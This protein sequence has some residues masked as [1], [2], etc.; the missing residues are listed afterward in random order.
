MVTTTPKEPTIEAP[1][2]SHYEPDMPMAFGSELRLNLKALGVDGSVPDFGE[3]LVRLSRDNEPYDF[4]FS[5]RG[6]LIVMAPSGTLSNRDETVIN[7]DLEMYNR[8][9]LSLDGR[10]IG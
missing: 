6:E 3:R 4:Q 10:G 2:A 8:Q 5:A 1:D 9:H 7:A